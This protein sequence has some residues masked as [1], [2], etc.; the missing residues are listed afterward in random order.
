MVQL[1]APEQWHLAV[2]MHTQLPKSGG[3]NCALLRWTPQA[4]GPRKNER[5]VLVPQ[6]TQR[7]FLAEGGYFVLVAKNTYK[8][9]ELC[10]A[11]NGFSNFKIGGYHADK[12]WDPRW[13]GPGV[14]K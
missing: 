13:D 9:M 8:T 4:K 14:L 12:R 1:V 11:K 7:S 6:G 10:K 2:P 5:V 3:T